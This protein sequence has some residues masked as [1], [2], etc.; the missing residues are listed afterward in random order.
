M[1]VQQRV[2]GVI[3][4]KVDGNSLHRHYVDHILVKTA[5]FLLAYTDYFKCVAMQVHWMLVAAY[6]FKTNR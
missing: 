2:A 1:A 3:C 5:N 4:Q 6:I